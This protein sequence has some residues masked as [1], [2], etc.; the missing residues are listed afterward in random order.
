MEYR[1]ES[2]GRRASISERPYARMAGEPIKPGDSPPNSKLPVADPSI[3]PREGKHKDIMDSS[4]RETLGGGGGPRARGPPPPPA[5]GEKHVEPST[6]YG[7]DRERPPLP[8][9]ERYRDAPGDYGRAPYPPSYAGHPRDVDHRSIR[10][11]SPYERSRDPR[12]TYYDYPPPSDYREREPYPPRAPPPLDY[13][14]RNAPYDE[15]YPPPHP[16]RGATMDLD[17]QRGREGYRDLPPRSQDS[18]P[19]RKYSASEYMDPYDDPRVSSPT[20]RFKADLIRHLG[21]WTVQTTHV[22]H[23]IM[24]TVI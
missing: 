1:D 2:S 15:R 17:T 9:A 18:R 12:D 21:T 8:P 11:E 3:S 16:P 4:T 10:G 13:P 22:P 6:G 24:M 20:P 5:L 7:Y 23:T 19:K 14:S